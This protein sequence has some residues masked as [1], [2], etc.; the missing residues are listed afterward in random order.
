[1]YTAEI[2]A[3]K[4]RVLRR[5][6]RLPRELRRRLILFL[7]LPTRLPPRPFL[8]SSLP[9]NASSVLSSSSLKHVRSSIL[10]IICVACFPCGVILEGMIRIHSKHNLCI[11]HCC[12]VHT[13]Y[14]TFSFASFHLCAPCLMHTPHCIAM[15]VHSSL[16]HFFLF[17]EVFFFR[18]W[19]WS[20][21][22]AHLGFSPSRWLA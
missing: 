8:M 11:L 15:L 18:F 2:T 14:A 22:N 13:I 17:R 20:R 9:N 1:M 10:S 19:Q 21:Q 3:R 6:L 5:K 4:S 7:L 12:I 16:L